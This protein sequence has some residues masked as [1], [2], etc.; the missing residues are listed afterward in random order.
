MTHSPNPPREQ[1]GEE[2]GRKGEKRIKKVS[3]R[4]M[5]GLGCENLLKYRYYEEYLNFKLRVPAPTVVAERG[6]VWY[7]RVDPRS[8]FTS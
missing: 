7:V 4:G 8:I 2:T 3:E 5:A 1:N 6:K